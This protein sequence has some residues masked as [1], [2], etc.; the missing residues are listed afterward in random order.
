M[1][2]KFML[3]QEIELY[4]LI[5]SLRKQLA[6][7]LI[8]KG[9]KQKEVARLLCITNA[10]ISQYLKGKRGK[11][12]DAKVKS[13]AK[14]IEK[15]AEIIR[16]NKIKQKKQQVAKELL[17]LVRIAKEKKINCEICK[18]YNRINCKKKIC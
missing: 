18:T 13:I 10:A 14:E 4:Y 6:V 7:A 11:R 9:L 17:R 8:N 15:S 3:P 1:P 16:K 5:P 12:F 2:K